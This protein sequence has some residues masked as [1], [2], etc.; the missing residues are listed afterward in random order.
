L[1]TEQRWDSARYYFE[2]KTGGIESST[3]SDRGLLSDVRYGQQK[4]SEV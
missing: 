2:V 4:C 1:L 3:I